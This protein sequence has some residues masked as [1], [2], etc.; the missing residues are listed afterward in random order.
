M[1]VRR[2]G[3]KGEGEGRGRWRRGRRRRG[4][5]VEVGGARGGGEEVEQGEVDEERWMIAKEVRRV[6]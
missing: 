2:G 6:E 5:E 1:Y 3:G 4:R